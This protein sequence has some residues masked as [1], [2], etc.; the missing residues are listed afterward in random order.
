M[1]EM[2]VRA[3]DEKT[4]VSSLS[5]GNQQKIM[6]GRW[7][8][9]GVDLL[10]IEEPTRGVD[11]GAKAE[12]YRLLRGFADAGG[13]ILMTSSELTEHLGLC[14]RILVVRE[15]AIVAEIPGEGATEESIMRHALMSHSAEEAAA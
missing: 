10:M 15:G 6:I 13:S 11:V 9:S 4:L 2:D 5:G 1:R 3:R 8:A 7:L 14:D 12:I